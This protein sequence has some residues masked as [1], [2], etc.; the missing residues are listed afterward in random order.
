M[1]ILKAQIRELIDLNA[2]L[3]SKI[4]RVLLES[5]K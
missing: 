2:A 5:E 1:E 4:A 3:E